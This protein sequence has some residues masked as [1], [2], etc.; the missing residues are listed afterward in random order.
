MPRALAVLTQSN[1]KEHEAR[2]QHEPEPYQ[3]QRENLAEGATECDRSGG[4][5]DHEQPG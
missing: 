2:R 3:R 1:L 5:R 4:A